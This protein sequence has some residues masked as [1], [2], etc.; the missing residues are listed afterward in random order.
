MNFLNI[1]LDLRNNTYE[2]CRKPDNHP[3]YIN[4][5]SNH[6]KTNL[7]KLPKLISKGLSDLPSSKEI[8]QKVTPIYYEALKKS[9]FN[10][11]FVFIPKANTIDN[12]SKKQRKLKII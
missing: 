5:N 8:F 11:S 2:P 6:S 12:T 3:A 10:Q 9:R 1:T 4:K 7:R